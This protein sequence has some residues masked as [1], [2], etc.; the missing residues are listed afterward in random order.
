MSLKF[1]TEKVTEGASSILIPELEKVFGNIPDR[2]SAPVFYNPRMRLNRDTSVL[3]LV[4]HQKRL[5]RPLVI[6]EP[7]CGTGVRGIRL[8]LEVPGV[9]KAILGDLNPNAV[10]LARKNTALNEVSEKVEVRLM[11]ANQ[12]LSSHGGPSNRFDYTDIDPYGSPSP[13][14]DSMAR[15]CRNNGM[16][17]LTATDMAP[18]CGVNPRACLRK[19]GGQPLRTKYCNETA[20]RLVIG[21]LVKAVALHKFTARPVFS[22][23][24]DHYVRIY[25][26][27][28]KGALAAD[29]GLQKIG[30]LLHCI[31]CLNRRTV[32]FHELINSDTCEVCGSKYKIGGP[33]WLG[34]I[35]ET[36]FCEEMLS[37]SNATPLSSNLRLIRLIKRV[38]GEVEFEPTYYNID[39]LCSKLGVASL[40]MNDVLS[41]LKETGFQAART[42]FDDRGVKTDA[43]IVELKNILKVFKLRGG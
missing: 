8:A 33:L 26:V 39:L 5:S 37:I 22:Y 6:C 10:M 31:N 41:A 34:K 20:L 18:L 40:P 25:A 2:T 42:H 21:A 35:A 13:Y 14:L 19:Y 12:L 27:L 17:A 32:N 24:A 3:A 43:S 4:V 36:D 28:E 30:F 38:Q 29:R 23:A 16:I 15:A 9:K 1:S 11:D 7:M